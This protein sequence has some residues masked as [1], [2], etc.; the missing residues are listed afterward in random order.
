MYLREDLYQ[1]MTLELAEKRIL[2]RF[3]Y[4]GL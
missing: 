3:G 2:Y 4:A 1:G